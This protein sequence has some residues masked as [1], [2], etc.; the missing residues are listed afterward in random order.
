MSNKESIS[1]LVST[2]LLTRVRNILQA[3]EEKETLNN[4]D[5]I[6]LAFRRVVEGPGANRLCTVVLQFNGWGSD[7]P[8][9]VVAAAQRDPVELRRA[10]LFGNIPCGGRLEPHQI[11]VL[12]GS[13][14]AVNPEWAKEI[15][16]RYGIAVPGAG[17]AGVVSPLRYSRDSLQQA[18]R[19][20][21]DPE[22][23]RVSRL[24]TRLGCEGVAGPERAL[25]EA[26]VA[27]WRAAE[28]ARKE[29][30]GPPRP[31]D[32]VASQAAY[33]DVLERAGPPERWTP[34]TL[35][36]G[37]LRM[38]ISQADSAVAEVDVHPAEEVL[39]PVTHFPTIV[40]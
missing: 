22:R 39:R 6:K 32:A 14:F 20:K 21:R 33:D 28:T 19:A 38:P 2:E 13:Q 5:V 10:R 15:A 40:L 37:E 34:F 4:T 16:F 12:E 11:L 23:Y 29:G 26:E 17:I 9:H 24:V 27:G 35:V 30:R 8:Q 36:S 7:V 3:Q 31:P 18:E 1:A 25:L